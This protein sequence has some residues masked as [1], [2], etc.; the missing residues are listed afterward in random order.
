MLSVEEQNLVLG[1]FGEFL[2]L[3]VFRTDY[4]VD[5]G[6]TGEQAGDMASIFHGPW[7]LMAT[8]VLCYGRNIAIKVDVL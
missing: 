2:L 6:E 8:A 7:Y 1:V 3:M 5:V 4:W